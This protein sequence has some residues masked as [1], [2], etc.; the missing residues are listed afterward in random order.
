MSRSTPGRKRIVGGSLRKALWLR[1]KHCCERCGRFIH[2]LGSEPDDG[3]RHHRHKQEYGGKNRLYNL[4]LVCIRCHRWIH[5]HE[6]LAAEEG[7][8][9]PADTAAVPLRRHDGWVLL[10]ADGSAEPLSEYAGKSL[11]SWVTS[12]LSPA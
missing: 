7:W 5:S 3:S 2:E 8:I 6:T 10:H 1:A 9:V 12:S 11:L 4:V